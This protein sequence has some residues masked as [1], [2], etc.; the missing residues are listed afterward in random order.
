[1]SP[2]LFH[3]EAALQLA[4][5]FWETYSV[6]Q[7]PSSEDGILKFWREI[8]DMWSSILRYSV[9]D[10]AGLR[11]KV[12]AELAY[13]ASNPVHA[14][15]G[16]CYTR[17]LELYSQPF[18]DTTELLN[19]VN[20]TAHAAFQECVA[21]WGTAD[22]TTRADKIGLCGIRLESL[23]EGGLIPPDRRSDVHYYRDSHEI[24]LQVGRPAFALEECLSLPFS[25][26]HEYLSHAFPFWSSDNDL[27]SDGLL[28]ALEF[29]WFD[30]S[31]SDCEAQFL[32]HV[33]TGNS[34]VST[35]QF[36]LARWYLNQ[37]PDSKCFARFLL[38]WTADWDSFDDDHHEDFMALLEGGAK[39]LRHGSNL[40][41]DRARVLREGI[42]EI[43]CNQCDD[44]TL[45]LQALFDRLQETIE[46]FS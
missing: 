42:Q 43:F 21:N 37:C 17:L 22:A 23:S 38:Q 33:W 12:A 6:W 29:N 13:R 14:S 30:R 40:S 28:F 39:R 3:F 44:K 41:P 4:T 24:L 35:L 8:S 20:Q 32:A 5:C 7:A 19:R 11:E 31:S 9:T 45:S 15:Y 10:L 1:L 26:F 25:F 46:R 16:P 34:G 36:G 18:A 27:V 2:R